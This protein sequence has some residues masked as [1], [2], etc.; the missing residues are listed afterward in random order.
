[1][2]ES[3]GEPNRKSDKVSQNKGWCRWCCNHI[4]LWQIMT[5]IEE[6]WQ[7]LLK[8]N[9]NLTFNPTPLSGLWGCPHVTQG[10]LIGLT[11]YLPSL[12]ALLGKLR[13]VDWLLWVLLAVFLSTRLDK[14]GICRR[15]PLR[16]VDVFTHHGGGLSEKLKCWHIWK[17]LAR[18]SLNWWV[19]KWQKCIECNSFLHI[20]AK[21]NVF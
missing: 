19:L 17:C 16:L 10:S 12:R 1:M 3:F 18:H 9:P 6:V 11:A 15:L 2:I 21:N 7:L 4:L 5:G 20:K 13:E 14:E 8:P